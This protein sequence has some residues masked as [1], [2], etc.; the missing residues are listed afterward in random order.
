MRENQER[1]VHMGNQ[2]KNEAES[3][4]IEIRQ[5]DLNFFIMRLN[6]RLNTKDLK[7]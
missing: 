3:F 6:G 5:I 4:E 7:P 2:N 1:C